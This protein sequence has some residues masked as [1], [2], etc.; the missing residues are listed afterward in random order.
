MPTGR[1]VALVTC[2]AFPD[3]WDDDH[4]LR[5]AL[6]SRGVA[7]DAVRW[8]EPDA[9][10]AG[11]DLVVVRSPWDYVA[12]HE[13]FVAWARSVPRLLNP[14]D[15]IVWNTDKRYIGELA[16]AGVPVIPTGFVGPGEAWTPP[17]SGEWVVK[18]TVSAGSQDTARYR[19]PA[20]A[21]QAQAHVG[22]LTAEGR[23][24][25]VQP[26]LA[27]V[28]TEG[29]TALLFFPDESGELAFS[30]AI[31]KGPM[32]RQTGEHVIDVGSEE[33]TPRTASEAEREVA[34]LALTAVPGGS[35]RLLYARVDVIPGPDGA[36]QVIE[37]ELSEPGL[38]LL[39]APGAADRLADAVLARL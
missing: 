19:L 13:Q 18:P 12:R 37:L 29:E 15:I 20:Q 24:A 33:I 36:P 21:A 27:A 8:D 30:H 34:R 31:R 9:D 17:S 25:M 14:A 38:F 6:R 28:A 16:A 11:Y 10:W 2:A 26:Y 4:P 23:T 39:T 22:R 3:L 32:L 1:R 35:K 5:D 7:V